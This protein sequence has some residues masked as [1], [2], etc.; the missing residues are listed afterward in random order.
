MESRRRRT[1]ADEALASPSEAASVLIAS[2]VRLYREGLCRA[3][4]AVGEIADARGAASIGAVFEA[5]RRD[6]PDVVIVDVAMP[7]ALDLIAEV[8][9]ACPDVAMLAVAVAADESDVIDCAEAGVH[10]Y[11]SRNSSLEDLVEAIECARRGETPCSPRVAADAFRRLAE[12]S[13]AARPLTER[14]RLTPRESEIARLLGQR[15]SNKQ[16]ARQLHIEVSTVKKH[17]RSVLKKLDV[18]SRLDVPARMK[19]VKASRRRDRLR[20]QSGS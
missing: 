13:S 16:I 8:S 11:V 10:G 17:V 2:D 9:S 1:V 20:S 4:A 3:L 7:W 6:E 5:L 15:L 12:L 14:P 18:T 19:W